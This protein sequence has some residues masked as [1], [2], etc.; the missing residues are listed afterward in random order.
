PS[1]PCA[2]AEKPATAVTVAAATVTAGRINP[3][4]RKRRRRLAKTRRASM[5]GGGLLQDL[6]RVELQGADHRQETGDGRH[7]QPEQRREGEELRHPRHGDAQRAAAQQPAAG[8]TGRATYETAQQTE[9]RRLA[10]EEEDDVAA[11]RADRDEE[12]RL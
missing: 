3:S 5:S 7:Q 6:R 11:R 12:P 2:R 4:C 1:P 10:E 8:Q 9:E